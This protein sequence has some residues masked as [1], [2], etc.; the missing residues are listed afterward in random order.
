VVCDGCK[1]FSRRETGR[2][3]VEGEVEDQVAAIREGREP[4]PAGKHQP[5]KG[6]LRRLADKFRD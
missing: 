3:P 2:F 6:M 5:A 4:P 1:L